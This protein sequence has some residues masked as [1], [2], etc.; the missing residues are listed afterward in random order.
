MQK[1]NSKFKIDLIKRCY[2]FSLN[3]IA[4]A[5]TVPNKIAAKIIIGQLIRSA[6]SIG[7][8]LTEAKAASSRLEFKKFHEIA[9][10]SANE[11]KYWLCLLRDAHLVN[12]NSAENLLKEVTEIANMIA[13]GILKLKN[14]KF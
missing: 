4:L 6:T 10:K 11:T 9:L 14:K 2:Q 7:A 1:Y 13:S 8:N 12:R 3:V 5:D